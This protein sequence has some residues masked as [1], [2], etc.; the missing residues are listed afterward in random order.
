MFFKSPK[1][2]G[3]G[4]VIPLKDPL[5]FKLK[6]NVPFGLDIESD[7]K[8]SLKMN[9]DYARDEKHLEFLEQVNLLQQKIRLFVNNEFPATATS[10]FFME[11]V[12]ISRI[13]QSNNNS[14]KE[15]NNFIYEQGEL[16]CQFR[17]KISI[18]KG[19]SNTTFTGNSKGET[20][21]ML[22]RNDIPKNTMIIVEIVCDSWWILENEKTIGQNWEIK[23]IVLL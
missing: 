20:K 14:N 22:T 9:I 11:P 10:Y 4:Y 21:R 8:W 2:T 7:W 6:V 17:G 23:D 19:K 18:K 16:L 3:K 5:N 13:E 1:N 15:T 12:I